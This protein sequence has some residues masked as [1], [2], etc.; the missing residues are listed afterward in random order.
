MNRIREIN[1]KT[2]VLVTP[3]NRFDNSFELMLG[4]WTDQYLRNYKV[5]EFDDPEKAFELA[6]TMPD[7]SWDKLVLFNKDNFQQLYKI[8]QHHI[9]TN[10]F[11]AELIAK[12]QSPNE[13]KNTMFER[14]I[15]KGDRFRLQSNL[16]DVFAFFIINPWSRNLMELADIIKLDHRLGI[17]KLVRDHNVTRLIGKTSNLTTYEIVFIPTVIYNWMR[18]GS[19]TKM[20]FQEVLTLQKSID[21]SVIIR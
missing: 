1:G 5:I 21:S 3:Y 4:N 7:L 13:L 12:I 19:N 20:G 8:V 17:Y 14:V 18:K 2:Q 10:E 9:A 6:Y 11:V 16:N 15:L